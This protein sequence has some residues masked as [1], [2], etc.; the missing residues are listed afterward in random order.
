MVGVVSMVG[1]WELRNGPLEDIVVLLE[2]MPWRFL[3]T[4]G[5]ELVAGVASK[6]GVNNRV[7]RGCVL[8]TAFR[9]AM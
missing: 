4:N 5:V 3:K 9:A 8:I 1:T 6:A 2:S 7:L